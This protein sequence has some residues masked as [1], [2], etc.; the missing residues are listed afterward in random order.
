MFKDRR[1]REY[2][3]GVE[4]FINFALQH[5]SNQSSIR[6][7]CMRCG[8]LIHH[9]P[10]KIREHMFF[11]GIDHSYHRWYWHGEAGPTSKQPSEMAQ[12]YDTMDCGD[13]ASTIEMVHA[14]EDEFMTDPKS[15]KQLLEDAKKPLY[16]GCVQFTKLSALVKL[17]NVKARYGWSDKSFSDLLQILGDMLP[18]NN[19]MPLSMYEAKKTLNALG[20]EYEKI[21]ACPNDCILYRNELKDASSCPTCGMSRWKANKAGVRSTKRIPG[22]VLWYFPP[23]PRFKRIFNLPKQLKT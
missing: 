10:N 1:S 12:C 23:I 3:E 18:V 17:Y 5:C 11:N 14:T 9:T 15:F 16:P 6:C 21:H 4:Y 19:E 22:K 13:V 2:E 20:M 8:N 7:P